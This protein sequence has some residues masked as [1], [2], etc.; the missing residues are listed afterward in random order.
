MDQLTREDFLE[1]EAH[2]RELACGEHSPEEQKKFEKMAERYE[3]Q[4]NGQRPRPGLLAE[5]AARLLYVF[6]AV[7]YVVGVFAIKA[8]DA[9]WRQADRNRGKQPMASI[10]IQ[11]RGG[12][13]VT[14]P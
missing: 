13:M 11:Q 12:A 7:L 10:V 9:S 2:C 1:M 14:A 6:G 8:A 5:L 3:A 4:A